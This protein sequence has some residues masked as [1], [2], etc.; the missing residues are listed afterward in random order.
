[1]EYLPNLPELIAA[2]FEARDRAYAP[3]SGYRVGA[4]VVSD[5]GEVARAGNIENQ[6]YGATVCAERVALWN[7]VS[8]GHRKWRTL[9]VATEDGGTPCGQCR[10]VLSEFA[11]PDSLIICVD[12]ARTL[13]Y[14]T[15]EE[16]L[17]FAFDSNEVRRTE[18]EAEG[19]YVTG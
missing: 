11:E 4:I 18:S 1:M 6:S 19:V 10:Q 3:Y 8:L 15:M 17:P 2:A 12:S 9:V 16:L 13:Q 7:L 5:S 14:F